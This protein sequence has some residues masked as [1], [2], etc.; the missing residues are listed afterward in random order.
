[1]SGWWFP[2]SLEARL[3]GMEVGCNEKE[4]GSR[5]KSRAPSW[6][7][8]HWDSYEGSNERHHLQLVIWLNIRIWKSSERI[9]MKIQIWEQHQ[10]WYMKSLGWMSS[11]RQR[12]VT[13]TRGWQRARIEEETLTF[14]KGR[15]GDSRHGPIPKWKELNRERQPERT[16]LP[17]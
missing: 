12:V 6:I 10:W 8:L 16:C 2:F 15:K 3:G 1:M 14:M 7:S 4:F 17:L 13:K 9:G 11:P 5:R